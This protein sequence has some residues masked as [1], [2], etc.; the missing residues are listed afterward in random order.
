LEDGIKFGRL[1]DIGSDRDT[2]RTDLF[3]SV[4]DG[5]RTAPDHDDC[6][7]LLDE[8]PCG[9]ET[10]PARTAS[11]N[12]NLVREAAHARSPLLVRVENVIF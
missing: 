2:I 8:L 7:A 9:R 5:P 11:D 12:D 4:T 6:G 10:D 1:R 3:L